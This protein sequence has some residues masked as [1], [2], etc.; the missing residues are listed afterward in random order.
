MNTDKKF[1]ESFNVD[2]W[3]VKTENGFVPIVTS[4]K[5]VKYQVYE[6]RTKGGYYLRAA[7][8]HIVFDAYNNEIFLKDIVL[9]TYIKTSSGLEEVI[10]ISSTDSY[11]NMYDL[12]VNSIYHSYYTNGILSHNTTTAALYLL[13]YAMFNDDKSVFVAAHK[14]S[15]AEEI[16]QRIRYAY[17]ACPDHIRCGTTTYAASRIVFDNKSSIEAQTTTENTGR[18][19]SISLLYCLDGNTRV[20]VRDKE[21]QEVKE[22]ELQGLY[23]ELENCYIESIEQIGMYRI[24]LENDIYI[25]IPENRSVYVEDEKV[26]IGDIT[27]GERLNYG[28]GYSKIIEIEYI[29]KEKGE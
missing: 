13:W 20:T 10:T 28:N 27:K 16:M 23:T 19:K 15:G 21:T 29:D 17:E 6:I 25:D 1:E 18:G 5:T 2:D 11:E 3:E 7:D 8:T 4:H 12:Q 24:T 9:G 14:G 26:D 22:I